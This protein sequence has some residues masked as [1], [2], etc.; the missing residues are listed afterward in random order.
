MQSQPATLGALSEAAHQ[1]KGAAVSIGAV[2]VA[3][4]CEQLEGQAGNAPAEEL[5][6][7][8]LESELAR[9]SDAMR[10]VLATQLDSAMDVLHPVPRHPVARPG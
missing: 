1:L 8:Q 2:V 4:V 7:T 6:L 3:A 9:A 10:D 5:L